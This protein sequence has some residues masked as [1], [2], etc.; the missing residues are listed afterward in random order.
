[1]SYLFWTDEEIEKLKRFSSKM[2]FKK[3]SKEHFVNRTPTSLQKKAVKL[4][5]ISGF[6]SKK[7]TFDENFYKTPNLVN[8][9]YAGNFA[10]DGYLKFR[11]NSTMYILSINTKD[12][13]ILNGF[14]KASQFGGNI[15]SYQRK[16]YLK[17]TLKDVSTIALTGIQ[18]WKNDL[19]ENF[20]I[21]EKKTLRLEPP[22]LLGKNLFAYI[23]GYIDGDGTIYYRERSPN[24]RGVGIR[25]YSSN[26]KIINWIYGVLSKVLKERNIEV[27]TNIYKKT[28]KNCYEIRFSGLGGAV[29]IDFFKKINTPKLARK[30]ENPEVLT[31]IDEQKRKFP[32]FFV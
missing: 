24:Q 27:T 19:Y 12:I 10:A 4:G 7:W 13:E 14:K 15:R 1:M 28:G 23:I 11:G 25:V 18:P 6:R 17:E 9:Y 20:G 22:N 8:S 21:T 3:M 31:Y 5:L 16:N 32:E 30:W 2:S 29:L 26:Y